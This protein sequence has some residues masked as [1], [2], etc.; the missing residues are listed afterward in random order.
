MIK[1][2]FALRWI[3]NRGLNNSQFSTFKT[4]FD[5]GRSAEFVKAFFGG[6]VTFGNI[7]N[8]K[9]YIAFWEEAPGYC[10]S[11]IVTDANGYK[12]KVFELI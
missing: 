1:A 12:I 11:A 10:P 4:L 2:L 7:D 8:D 9:Y 3:E 6:E 5:N